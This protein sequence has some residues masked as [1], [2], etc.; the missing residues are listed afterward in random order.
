MR[1]IEAFVPL[2]QSGLAD[3]RRWTDLPADPRW[4]RIRGVP[5]G[6]FQYDG[7]VRIISINVDEDPR[8]LAPL[9]LHEIAHCLDQEYLQG[10]AR[11]TELYAQLQAAGDLIL[12]EAT[13]RTGVA[14]SELIQPHLRPEEYRELVERRKAFEKFQQVRLFRTERKAYSALHRWVQEICERLPA[15]SGYLNSL[16]AHGY[17]FDRHITDQEIVHGYALDARLVLH[18]SAA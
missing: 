11:E 18:R 2:L 4:G 6:G 13:R 17:T 7:H 5:A 16:R 8:L 3:V 12:P 15:Y 10:Y 9:L 1:K 14:M